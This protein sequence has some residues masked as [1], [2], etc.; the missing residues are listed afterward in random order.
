MSR[1]IDRNFLHVRL[2]ICYDI[3]K[4]ICDNRTI[5]L[6]LFSW[7]YVWL[8]DPMDCGRPGF[9]ALHHIPAFA[10]VHVRWVGDAIQPSYPVIPFFCL[11]SFP[12]SGSFPMT[13]LF[14]WVYQSI[15]ASAS[16]SVLPVNIQ[17]WFL[18]GLTGLISLQ[19]RDSQESYPTPQFES[20]SSLVLDFMVQ[21]SHPYKTTEKTIA[22]TICTFVG[23]VMSLFCNMLSRFFIT[24]LP[25]SKSLLISLL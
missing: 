3:F 12:E 23:K 15:R 13:L 4:V 14:T 2:K 7:C 10:Q 1:Y 6:L 21:L 19:L 16:A 22:L 5:L 24:F 25:R 11:Q 9:P 8:C 20:I 17:G 18:L